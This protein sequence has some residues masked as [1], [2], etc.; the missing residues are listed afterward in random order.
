[1]NTHTQPAKTNYLLLLTVM[2]MASSISFIVSTNG[3]VS[4]INKF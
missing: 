1:M 2:Q 4:Y 3:C